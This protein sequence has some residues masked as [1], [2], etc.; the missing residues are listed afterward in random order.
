LRCWGERVSCCV[1]GAAEEEG[2]DVDFDVVG[3]EEGAEFEGVGEAEPG[4]GRYLGVVSIS[5]CERESEGTLW[6][7]TINVDGE[8]ATLCKT[9]CAGQL[10]RYVELEDC[11]VV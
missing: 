10:R 5:S 3:G 7:T 9:H 2:K 8:L 6:P 11:G 1:A 4:V